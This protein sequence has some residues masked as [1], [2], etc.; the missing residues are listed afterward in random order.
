MTIERDDPERETLP[1]PALSDDAGLVVW[2]INTVGASLVQRGVPLPQVL[3]LVNEAFRVFVRVRD[4][5]EDPGACLVRLI[6]SRA[7]EYAGLRGI[8]RDPAPQERVPLV[9]DL[10]T[11]KEAMATLTPTGR[12]IMQL[13]YGQK[14]TLEQIAAALGMTVADVE[15]QGGEAYDQLLAWQKRR[16]GL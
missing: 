2:A 9:V 1:D 5:V 15:L 10:V 14:K 16:R 4:T 12:R 6:E 3:R 8:E 11:V 7:A 13:V